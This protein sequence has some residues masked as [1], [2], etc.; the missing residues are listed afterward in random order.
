[1]THVIINKKIK[2][3]LDAEMEI[4]FL[5]KRILLTNRH[6]EKTNHYSEIVWFSNFRLTIW[7]YLGQAN[8]TIVCNVYI[9]VPE[10]YCS[11]KLKAREGRSL[12]K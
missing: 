9:S 1:M 8:I 6:Y 4:E 3:L 7:L 12:Q 5:N 2:T 10:K 11:R